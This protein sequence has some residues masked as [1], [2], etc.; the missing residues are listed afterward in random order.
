MDDDGEQGSLMLQRV[1]L[2]QR[3][4]IP[5]HTL[6]SDLGVLKGTLTQVD[7]A[8]KDAFRQHWGALEEVNAFTLIEQRAPSDAEREIIDQALARLSRVIESLLGGKVE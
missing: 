4:A 7:A 1:S 5:L 8:W 6:V 2:Y 3:G